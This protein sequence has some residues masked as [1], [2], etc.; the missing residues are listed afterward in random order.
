MRLSDLHEKKDVSAKP[1]AESLSAKVTAIQILA[2]KLLK[3][4]IT[5]IPAVLICVI[6]EVVYEDE[7]GNSINLKPGDFKEIEPMVKHWVKGIRDAQ[8]VL[9]K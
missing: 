3:E 9:I 7:K 1:L 2:G 5:T 8:L 6:G 4:H